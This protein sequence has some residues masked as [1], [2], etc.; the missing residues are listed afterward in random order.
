MD[1]EGNSLARVLGISVARTEV[2][3][4]GASSMGNGLA[5][6]GLAGLGSPIQ[7]HG[8]HQRRPVQPARSMLH[9]LSCYRSHNMHEDKY[10]P[11]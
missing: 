5:Q 9:M 3:E 1:H 6:A 11:S 7:Q 10:L 4:V 2:E 8:L